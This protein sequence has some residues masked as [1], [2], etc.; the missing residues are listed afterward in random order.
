MAKKRQTHCV[1]QLL[2]TDMPDIKE[3]KKALRALYKEK[4]RLIDADRKALLD[5]AL[6]ENILRLESFISSDTLLCFYPSFLEPD[7]LPIA[8]EALKLG[9]ALAFPLCDTATHTMTFRYVSSLDE[10]KTGSYSIPEPPGSNRS[11]EGEANT[12][13]L[14]PALTF[15]HNG[16]RL[17]YGGGYYDRFLSGFCGVSLGVVYEELVCRKLPHGYFDVK[18]DIIITERGSILTND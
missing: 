12:L 3:E 7:V 11:Y 10:L 8:S 16:Y 2:P 13:C 1:T 17:G 4:R 15:D 6:C 14:V 9:K 5:K 18:A